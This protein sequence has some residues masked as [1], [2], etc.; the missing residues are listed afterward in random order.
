MRERQASATTVPLPSAGRRRT[1]RA[2][3]GSPCAAVVALGMAGGIVR[4]RHPPVATWRLLLRPAV[5]P[6][7]R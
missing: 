5:R 4:L 2:R 1:S 7:A 6:S 3:A